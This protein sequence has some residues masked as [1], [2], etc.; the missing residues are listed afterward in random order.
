VRFRVLIPASLAIVEFLS[1]HEVFQV[2][3]VCPD[4]HWVLGSLQKVSPLF[5][6]IDDSK[7]LLIMNLTIL[8]HQRQGFAVEG[9]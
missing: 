7:H 3:V 5:Q 6:Y 1:C 9:H 4:F 8:L 2:L